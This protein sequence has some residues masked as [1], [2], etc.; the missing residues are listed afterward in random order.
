MLSYVHRGVFRA[1]SNICGS[2]FFAKIVNGLQALSISAKSSLVDVWLV[3]KYASGSRNS[4]RC[5]V[6]KAFLKHFAIFSGKHLFWSLFLTKLQAFFPH[7]DW[8]RVS[9]CIQS[10]W[11]KKIEKKCGYFRSLW[12]WLPTAVTKKCSERCALQ[13]YCT[14]F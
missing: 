10:K 11:G 12:L 2:V 14:C 13:L 6:E 5:S 4:H 3:S 9:L 1:Q 8:I 7:S